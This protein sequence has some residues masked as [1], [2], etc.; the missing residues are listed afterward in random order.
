ML[1]LSLQKRELVKIT[2]STGEEIFVCVTGKVAGKYRLA[3]KADI[4]IKI[5]RVQGEF[6]SEKLVEK[7]KPIKKV[8]VGN[9]SV[10]V[11]S[12]SESAC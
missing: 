11:K 3:F 7:I 12:S 5:N 9:V 6:V 4:S 1:S 8:P 2:T 10:Q